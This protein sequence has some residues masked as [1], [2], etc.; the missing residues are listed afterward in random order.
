MLDRDEILSVYFA[1]SWNYALFHH[2][3]TYTGF[4]VSFKYSDLFRI[5]A[6]FVSILH[7]TN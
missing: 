2:F 4:S 5:H 6:E 3:V 1:I 7:E